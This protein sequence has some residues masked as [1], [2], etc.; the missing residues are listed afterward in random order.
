MRLVFQYFVVWFEPN[1]EK[2]VSFLK[3]SVSIV[4]WLFAL[5]LLLSIPGLGALDRNSESMGGG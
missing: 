3:R 4:F 5:L 2:P 1:C